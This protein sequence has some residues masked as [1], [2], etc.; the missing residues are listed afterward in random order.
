MELENESICAQFERFLVLRDLLENVN[1][2]E[3]YEGKASMHEFLSLYK[4]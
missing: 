4:D 1:L 2:I 3:E